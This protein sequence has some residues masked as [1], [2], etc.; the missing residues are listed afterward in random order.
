MRRSTLLPGFALALP[1]LIAGCAGPSGPD[2]LA[3]EPAAGPAAAAPTGDEEAAAVERVAW[4]EATAC[5]ALLDRLDAMWR[6]GRWPDNADDAPLALVVTEGAA[7]EALALDMTLPRIPW[8]EAEGY[9]CLILVDSPE[10]RETASDRVIREARLHASYPRDSKRK[11]N[12]Q[13]EAI[14]KEIARLDSGR[15]GG[16]PFIEPTGDPELDLWGVI[17]NG[18]IDGFSA[19]TGVGRRAEL[20][21][22]LEATPEHV[23]EPVMSPYSYTLREL[24]ATRAAAYRVALIDA[25]A[26]LAWPG[27]IARKESERFALSD[28]RHPGDETIQH[29]PDSRLVTSSDLEDWRTSPPPLEV[30]RLVAEL[31]GR[32]AAT[33]AEA[34]TLPE[35]VARWSEA[36]PKPLVRAAEAPPEPAAGPAPAERATEDPAA[37]GAHGEPD[38]E[39]DLAAAGAGHPSLVRVG[40]DEEGFGF[41]V[42]PDLILT[43]TALLA[44]SSLVAVTLDD[45]RR[46]YGVVEAEDADL[47][48]ALVY[49]PRPGPPLALAESDGLPRAAGAYLDDPAG[50]PLLVDGAVAAITTGDAV[51][52]AGGMR[53]LLERA[54][55]PL[56]TS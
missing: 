4:P 20:E 5:P 18:V 27:P 35:L 10:R 38:R 11:S 9:R 23:E 46:I 29:D 41:Y 52:P 2:P 1:A 32:A 24:E 51:V 42:D 54:G 17:A 8:R 45:G 36:A 50:L 7:A 26:G 6:D 48:L 22:L 33:P 53:R 44:D 13:Y 30:S 21:S 19:L 39:P 14:E 56:P 3:T 49:V 12:P 15:G 16:D 43:A 31:A 25:E 47:G 37:S 40:D 34:I 55:N 28:D